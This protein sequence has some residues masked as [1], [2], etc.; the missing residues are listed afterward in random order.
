MIN[1]NPRLSHIKNAGEMGKRIAEYD[2]SATSLGPS[3]SWP[4]SL[5]SILTTILECKFAMYLIW[6][7]DFIQFYNDAYI[8][9]LGNKHP[10]SLGI[11][12]KESW[13]EI[14]STIGPLFDQ[15]L[16]GEN[17]IFKDMPLDILSNG[18]FVQRN[19]TFCY[20]PVRDDQNQII[21]VLD[22][23]IETTEEVSSKAKLAASEETFRR[24]LEDSPSPFLVIDSDWIIQ[25]MNPSALQ[26]LN[27]TKENIFGK[28]FWNA[29]PGLEGTVFEENY[30]KVMYQKQKVSFEGYYQGYDKWYEVTSYPLKDG[31]ALSFSDISKRKKLEH[32]LSEA[33]R[34]KDEFLSVA[35]HELKTPLTSLKL[36]AQILKRS[37]NPDIEKTL[38]FADMADQQ[39]SRLS[40]LVEDMLDVSRLNSGKLAF[41]RENFNFVHLIKETLENLIP[42]FETYPAGSPHL[43]ITG[44]DFQVCWDYFRI[45]Q[46]INN[47]LINA[48]RYGNNLP[49]EVVARAEQDRIVFSIK[50]Q[51]IGIHQKD[52]GLIFNRFERIEGA[53]V[54]EVMGLGLYITKQIVE[55]HYGSISVS[56]IP[57]QGSIFTVNLPRS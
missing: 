4:Q 6:G 23:V 34:A 51:G 21:G 33:V 30:H 36:H 31:L 47:L 3:E 17:V 5:V 2:W 15:A 48:I 26:I 40:R 54:R 14:W 42:L 7:K 55:A 20:S 16:K 35:S 45:E 18:I 24:F 53:R 37:K 10:H 50:D 9:I 44:E 49:I 11:H 1:L 13:S 25:Y 52:L 8:E 56:S 32:D 22:T 28:L 12:S 19:F 46:V 57:G 27:L 39:V 29:F 43:E 41:H 38:R